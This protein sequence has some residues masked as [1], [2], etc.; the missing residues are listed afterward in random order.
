M[1]FRDLTIRVLGDFTNRQYA[2]LA[3]EIS[4]RLD[5]A[6][7]GKR[8]ILMTDGKISGTEMDMAYILRDT[9]SADTAAN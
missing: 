3:Y 7:L 9:G 6:G 2:S 1:T 5:A 4:L 8:A